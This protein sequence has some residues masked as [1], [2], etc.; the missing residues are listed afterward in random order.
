LEIPHFFLTAKNL[1]E[2][3]SMTQSL[4]FIGLTIGYIID[5]LWQKLKR[6]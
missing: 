4:P 2:Y 1:V 3:R 5:R 6:F